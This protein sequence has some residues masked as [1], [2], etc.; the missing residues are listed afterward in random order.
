MT[1]IKIDCASN[2]VHFW[3]I[4]CIKGAEPWTKSVLEGNLKKIYVASNLPYQKKQAVSG[5]KKNI[6]RTLI[7]DK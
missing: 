2:Y 1:F 7:L 4:E 5:T 6:S 3:L